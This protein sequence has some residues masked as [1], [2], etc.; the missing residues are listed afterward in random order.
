MKKILI[1]S[2]SRGEHKLTFMDKEI[3][4]EKIKNSDKRHHLTL[5]SL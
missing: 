5:L 4:T 2:D 3:F 1:F